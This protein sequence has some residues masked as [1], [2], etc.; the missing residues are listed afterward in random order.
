MTC[1]L[2]KYEF[3]WACGASATSADR[4]FEG[5][6]GCGVRMMDDTVKAGRYANAID[7]SS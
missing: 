7:E 3:C 2:C 1:Y 4:H 6:N 5:F